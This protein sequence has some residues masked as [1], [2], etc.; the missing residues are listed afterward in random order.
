[1]D[2]DGIFH[3]VVAQIIGLTQRDAGLDASARHPHGEGARVVIAPEEFG[4]IARASFMGVRPNS[5]PQTTSVESS[6]PRCFRSLMSAAEALVGLLAE[7]GQAVDD[8]VVGGGAVVVPAAMIELHEANA[9]LHQPPRQ[10]AIVGKRSSCRV[11]SRTFYGYARVLWKYRPG[12]ERWFAS[13]TPFRRM[14]CAWQFP[15]RPPS[16]K[17]ISFRSFKASRDSR[18]CSGETPS[19]LVRYSTGSPCERNST[20]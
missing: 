19:G 18:R 8:V 17:C 15:D 14:Q 13:C 2:V 4:L 6:N 9:A 1:M 11:R 16:F 5:P 7:F 3:D 10:Q 12:R 20:P